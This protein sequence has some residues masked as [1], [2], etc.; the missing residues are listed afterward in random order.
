MVVC[1]I[2]AAGAWF[3]QKITNDLVIQPIEEMIKRVKNITKDPLKAA[4]DEEERLL[5]E[6]T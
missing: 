4:Q 5:Y 6:E 3:F 2:L 1:L